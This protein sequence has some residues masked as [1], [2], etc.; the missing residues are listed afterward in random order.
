MSRTPGVQLTLDKVRFKD[1][2]P[3]VS[4]R[5][6][7]NVDPRQRY[8]YLQI[9][10]GRAFLEHLHQSES[11]LTQTKAT[12]TLHVHWRGQR[13]RS[14]AILCACDPEI[15]EGFLLEVLKDSGGSADRMVDSSSMLAIPDSVHLV[16]IKTDQSGDNTL[17]SS[18]F[19]EGEQF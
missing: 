5:K 14:K 12:F 15:K 2:K 8:L 9:I 1:K 13:F 17:L 18:H 6:Q 19:I 16:L 11:H 4:P 7:V 10:G 3:P